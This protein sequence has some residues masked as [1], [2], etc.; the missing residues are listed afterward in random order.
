MKKIFIT[1]AL[2]GLL[3]TSCSMNQEPIGTLSDQ[4]AILNVKDAL[5]FRNGLYVNL[6]GVSNG[7]YITGQDL[8]GDNFV[9]MTTNGNR[10]GF[11]SNKTG[12]LSNNTQDLEGLW[13]GP[14][15][16]IANCNYF[17]EK[18]EPMIVDTKY[19]EEDIIA[20]KRYRGEALFARAYFYWYL[21]DRFCNSYTIIDPNSPN[22]GVP[23]VTKYSPTSEYAA[24]PGRNTLAETFA[25]IES[26]L[27]ASYADISSYENSG[28][29]G[30][31]S[32][33]A[34][35]APYLSTYAIEALQARIALLKG[36]WGTAIN[37]AESVI[38]VNGSSPFQLCNQ[39]AYFD[40]WGVDTGSELIFLP[41]ANSDQSAGVAAIGETFNQKD[42]QTSDYIPTANALDLYG[43][44]DIERYND[45]RYECFFEV[46]NLRVDGMQVPAPVFVKYPGNPA[47]DAG[48]TNDLKNLG[49][50]FRLS[51]MYLIVAEAAANAS[52]PDKANKA[53]NDL[54]KAR[55]YDYTPVDYSGEALIEQIRRERT[56]ELIGEGFRIS[57]LRRW[58]LGFSRSD[59]YGQ[60]FTAVPGALVPASI[61]VTYS[62]T[63]P[64]YVLP[65]PSHEMETNPQ[66]VQNPGY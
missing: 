38:G 50:P 5:A 61:Q 63:D 46:R 18:I 42:G 12:I 43:S 9:G 21:A 13:S 64:K 55:L 44:D 54:R 31:T 1:F 58:K 40:M 41:Y 26:D 14:Y 65:I 60:I 30:S 7:G 24:Y 25:Q 49:K 33:L 35:N 59:N 2:S 17:L 27:N 52:Q 36:D 45:V 23:V 10:G 48:S 15:G 28:L 47:F 56:K 8:Q 51:E 37:K 22:S 34:P 53:L 62:A 3:L 4:D 39:D 11:W 6:R 29:Q 57:D 20:L 32:N 19:T 66:M 16:A